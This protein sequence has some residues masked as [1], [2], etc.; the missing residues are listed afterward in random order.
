MSD[1][2]RLDRINWDFPGVGTPPGSIHSLHWFPGNFIPQ[3]PAALIQVLSQ[4]RQ[5]VFDPFAGSG[6]TGIEALVLG[7]RATLSDINPV[8]VLICEAKVALQMGAIQAADVRTILSE[9]SFDHICAS[10]RSGSRG[11]GECKE[12]EDWFHADT[13]AQLR[14]LWQ[15]IEG[16]SNI[17]LRKVLVAVFS[18]ALFACASSGETLSNTGKRRRRH[19]G[20]IADNVRPRSLQFFNAIEAF[21]ERLVRLEGLDAL[22]VTVKYEEGQ[23][24]SS[25]LI[26]AP[27]IAKQDA[28]NL[29]VADGSIDLIVTS[30]PYVSMIDYTHANRLLYLWMG[31]DLGTERAAEIGARYRRKRPGVENEYLEDMRKVRNELARVLRPDGMCAIV[32]GESKKFPGTAARVL[33]DFGEALELVWGP[34]TRTPTRRRVSDRAALEPTETISVFKRR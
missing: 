30:P 6:T 9:L 29:N 4:P 33:S 19:W 15:M 17:G 25:K 13:L 12:L 31:W 21:R 10:D 7:R 8:S 14:Y 34:A 2:R 23:N 24:Q 18:D 5:H 1:L 28:R 16:N 26:S 20:W 3:I 32:I 22:R 11:E 27:Q